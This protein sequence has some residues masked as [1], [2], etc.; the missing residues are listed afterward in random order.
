MNYLIC[1]IIY[2]A[3]IVNIDCGSSAPSYTDDF[4]VVWTGDTDYISNGMSKTVPAINSV[5]NVLNTLRVF[6]SRKKNCYIIP[7]E[8]GG[9][10][11]VVA[12]FYYG[13]Y[14]Q[15][16]SPPS[17]DLHFDG[18][19]WTTVQTSRT[20]FEIYE[21]IY[22]VKGDSTSICLAQTLPGQY[23]FISALQ[24]R[25]LDLDMYNSM[26]NDRALSLIKRVAYGANQTVGLWR[27]AVP[28]DGLIAV[29]NTESP[30][31]LTGYPDYPPE[32][33][34]RNAETLTN[35]SN[36]IILGVTSSPTPIR[37]YMNLYFSEVARL[38]FTDKRSFTLY[39]DGE[40]Y[41]DPIL[42]PFG[43][44]KEVTVTADEVT[45]DTKFSLDQ[46]G[47][48]T[49][50]PLINA[51]EVFYVSDILTNGTNREDVAGLALLQKTFDVLRDWSGDPCLPAPYSWDWITCNSNSTP[52]VTALFL[53]SFG[54][55]GLLPDISSMDFLQ[56]I[57]TEENDFY[58]CIS[59]SDLNNNSL[60]GPI[61]E[62][63]GSLPYLK[64]LNLAN[65]QFS[66]PIPASLSKKSNLNLVTPPS[67][68]SGPTSSGS[69]ASGGSS[70]SEKKSSNKMLFIILGTTIPA[71]VLIC[72]GVI[73]IVVFICCR[74]KQPADLDSSNYNTAV[75]GLVTIVLQFPTQL[76]LGTG[77][78]PCL[79]TPLDWIECSS[80]TYPRVTA[81]E[82]QH[83]YLTGYIPSFLGN[84]PYLEEFFYDNPFLNLPTPAQPPSYYYSPP[85]YGGTPP[86]TPFYT[87]T[88]PSSYGG[89]SPPPPSYTYY[90]PPSL[91]G[92]N[93]PPP[94]HYTYRS[95]YQYQSTPARKKKGSLAAIIGGVAGGL[96]LLGAAVG[97]FAVFRHK[98]R[99]TAAVAQANA[100]RN[101]QSQ[102]THGRKLGETNYKDV[103]GLQKIILAFPILSLTL[104]TNDDPCLPT[105]LSWI[106]C[107]SATYPR[108]TALDLGN[109]GLFGFIPDFS[110]M[111]ALVTIDMSNNALTGNVPSF[112]GFLPNLEELNLANNLLTGYVPASILQNKN[113][114]TDFSGNYALYQLPPPSPQIVSSPPFYGGRSPPPPL[115]TYY[116]PPSSYAGR[117]P[118]PPPPPYTYQ[119][120]YSYQI[121][122]AKKKKKSNLAAIVGGVAGGLVLV[123]AVVGVF[124]VFQHKSRVA[125][126]VAQANAGGRTSAVSSD[127]RNLQS[128][129]SS[130]SRVVG[131]T[132]SRDVQGLQTLIDQFVTLYLTTGSVDPC[133]PTPLSWIECNSATSPRVT[134]LYLAS[135][136]LLGPIPDFSVMD[137]LE[138]IDMQNNALTGNIPSFLGNMPN[139][140]ELNLANNILSGNIP[141]S[142]LQNK[143]LKTDFSGNSLLQVPSS[144]SGGTTTTSTTTYTYASTPTRK[145]KSNLGAIIGGVAG[146]LTLIGAAV[147][148]FAMF[149]HKAKVAA[150]VAQAN[151][152]ATK[153]TQFSTGET[154]LN[155]AATTRS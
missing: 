47:A 122:P 5:S 135:A 9:K 131:G 101:L 89:G 116:N 77:V 28:G 26:D 141:S 106:E 128:H 121:T 11:L 31:I 151:A 94:P 137:A 38:N 42:P 67:T 44:F 149:Q 56:T 108:V 80:G 82:M 134:A 58:I 85:L 74:K 60:S 68:N 153:P 83:N 147:G 73:C 112:L 4:S 132:D 129:I 6:T 124:A 62:F 127:G 139:L 111:D 7:A 69:P 2:F 93:P 104:G 29:T 133:L 19:Y 50:P 125:A 105:R 52:R 21:V 95:P 109:E 90:S 84:L 145:K 154:P 126:A 136:N 10:V 24:V 144:S 140:K 88:P 78:D 76:S 16:S 71:L 115:Y 91:Y 23:P 40:S 39:K 43:G 118:P 119:T 114:I 49:L 13:N 36:T 41:S 150:A 102:I 53:S 148:L 63:L 152:E 57:F 138:T 72:V 70:S 46:D 113:L 30:K 17:F 45:S 75:I 1:L 107:S 120:P 15:K 55:T 3:V 61:P 155:P 25:S 87:Y 54:L 130:F 37:L 48:S 32:Q 35:A 146:G 103:Q 34:L 18:N 86:A 14:D 8:Q 27:P 97:V 142:I 64:Q 20:L 143:K 12:S 123:G 99:V 81:L 59:F 65:N 117:S 33:V 110:I 96:I 66:G 51:K 79:P 98:S 92:G 100:G 22:V